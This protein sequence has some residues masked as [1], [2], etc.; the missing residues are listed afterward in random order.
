MF[1][2]PRRSASI[3]IAMCIALLAT[4]LGI[5]LPSPADPPAAS[6]P[7][8][9][10]TVR[11]ATYNIEH[12]MR[13]FD[14]I[15]MP[16]RSRDIGELYDDEEELYEV[17]RV[18]ELPEM[19]PDILTIQECCS[20]EMLEWFNREYL[21]GRYSFVHVFPS[22]V[23]G[24]WVGVMAVAGFEPLEVLSFADEVDPVDDPQVR[25]YKDRAGFGE[26]NALFSRG[27]G[28]VLFRTP[29]GEQL[30]VGTTHVKSKSG[31]SEP[32]TRWRMRELLRTRE[33]CGELLA[34]GD[35]DML[36]VMGDFND[37]FGLDRYEQAL[38]Q[39]AVALMTEGE[40]NEQLVSLTWPMVRA[41]PTLA[42]YHCEIKPPTY[43]SFIDHVFAS[44]AL[45]GRV[46][47]CYVVDA[48]IAAVASDHYPVVTVVELGR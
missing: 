39:D 12:F 22:N 18:I 8:A 23:E 5:V 14:Q 38:G 45:A 25:G 13:M 31:N 35:S 26:Q 41:D 4:W 3:L 32:V 36:A 19:Q 7:S 40:G 33:I 10:A 15:R 47:D 21:D 6:Q 24:Q 44:G 9:G 43:R 37:D 16:E 20:Q 11:L 1:R 29:T 30:W 27:P 42:T 46:R 2:K 28:F 48:P 17:A 34:R